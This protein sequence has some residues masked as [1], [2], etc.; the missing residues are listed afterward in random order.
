MAQTDK[1]AAWQIRSEAVLADLRAEVAL[2][3]YF[4]RKPHR[5]EICYTRFAWFT[6]LKTHETEPCKDFR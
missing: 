3:D 6:E 2:T 1:K 5:C 4:S